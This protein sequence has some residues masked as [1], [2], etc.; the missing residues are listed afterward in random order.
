MEVVVTFSSHSR[1]VI[2]V[3]LNGELWRTFAA[4]ALKRAAELAAA[5]ASL[6][7]FKAI[8]NEW[9][10]KRIKTMAYES[11]SRKRYFSQ[12]LKEKLLDLGFANEGI[13]QVLE[14]LTALGYLND[15][16]SIESFIGSKIHAGRGP[17]WISYKLMQ[18][19]MG[20]PQSVNDYYPEEERKAN[21]LAFI[22]KSK[23]DKQKTIASLARKGFNL[24]EII[25]V[26][27][28]LN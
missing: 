25:S 2:D 12:E 16:E 1:H 8:W 14:E 13:E 4:S 22:Q 5:Y 11:L 6:E 23:K 24:S 19:G 27:N 28:N 17:R 20:L 7:V 26:Y 18:K 21:I 9:E 3:H 10:F 15:E